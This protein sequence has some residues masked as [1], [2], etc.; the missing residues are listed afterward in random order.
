[1]RVTATEH[2][3]LASI[4]GHL[5]IVPQHLHPVHTLEQLPQLA[6]LQQVSLALRPPEP[7]QPAHH[8]TG[9]AR[10]LGPSLAGSATPGSPVRAPGR[11]LQAAVWFTDCYQARHHCRPGELLLELSAGMWAV[12]C[13]LK[14]TILQPGMLKQGQ[15]GAEGPGRWRIARTRLGP[16]GPAGGVGRHA[17]GSCDSRARQAAA[18]RVSPTRGLGAAGEG[19]GLQ[20]GVAPEGWHRRGLLLPAA[21][22]AVRQGQGLQRATGAVDTQVPAGGWRPGHVELDVGCKGGIAWDAHP[23]RSPAQGNSVCTGCTACGCNP[24]LW[25]HCVCSLVAQAALGGVLYWGEG[26]GSCG[27]AGRCCH[28]TSVQAGAALRCTAAQGVSR[29]W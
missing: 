11:A 10:G 22:A 18:A 17:L 29:G 6:P 2:A 1:M 26:A 14:R 25:G 27:R 23:Q 13:T 9:I 3:E 24:V 4:C 12:C 20:G 15:A 21:T 8:G 28:H 5:H 7:D 16:A 19:A